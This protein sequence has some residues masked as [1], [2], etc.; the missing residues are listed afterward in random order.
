MFPPEESTYL[1]VVMPKKK[2][3]AVGDAYYDETANCMYVIGNDG[4]PIRVSSNPGSYEYASIE[5]ALKA[6]E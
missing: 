1:R 6:R 4:K 2:A 3:T 5:E